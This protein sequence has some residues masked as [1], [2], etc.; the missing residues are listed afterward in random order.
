MRLLMKA[1][2]A[3]TR[4]QPQENC[5]HRNS[6]VVVTDSPIDRGQPHMKENHSGGDYFDGWNSGRI[7][8]PPLNIRVPHSHILRRGNQ[9]QNQRVR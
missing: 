8:A 5:T 6:L 1:N 7:T 3:T 2:Q 9:N 4:Q